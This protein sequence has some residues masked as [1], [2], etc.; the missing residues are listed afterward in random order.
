MRESA[1]SSDRAGSPAGGDQRAVAVGESLY[2]V[3]T[4]IRARAIQRAG[5]LLAEV[6]PKPG[7]RTDLVRSGTRG[8]S[9]SAA[10]LSRHERV[11]AMRVAAVP[12]ADFEKAVE[13]EHPPTIPATYTLTRPKIARPGATSR[14]IFNRR[15]A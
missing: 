13:S 9:A 4:R 7:A 15:S 10:G 12:K 6:E 2:R 3:A 11:T 5:Q 1:G 14:E 8:S